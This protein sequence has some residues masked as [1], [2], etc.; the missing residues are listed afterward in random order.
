MF[1]LTYAF[2]V[3]CC[4]LLTRPHDDYDRWTLDNFDTIWH[5][6]QS[7]V[8]ICTVLSQFLFFNKTQVLK[9]SILL[10]KSSLSFI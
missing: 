6:P 2:Y 3:A 7:L 9:S 10:N 1:Y 5:I 8:V 4:V